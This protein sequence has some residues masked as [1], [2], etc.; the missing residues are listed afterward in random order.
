MRKALAQTLQ[1]G[2]R[3]RLALLTA[4]GALILGFA[5]NGGLQR[6]VSRFISGGRP[7]AVETTRCAGADDPSTSI[8]RSRKA[9]LCLHNVERHEQGVRKVH[10]NH[11]LSGV[12]RAQARD[13]VSRHYFDHVSPSHK[14]HMDR[15]AAS[16]Y[17]PDEGCWSAGE[18][19]LFAPAS[20]TPRQLLRT[21]MHSAAHRRNI[22]RRGWRD[23]GYGVVAKSPDGDPHGLT[24]VA[25]FGTRTCG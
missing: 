8:R 5:A 18:N 17:K 12:A 6:A 1:P 20:T 15:I 10:W 4:L 14:D 22:E 3:S 21:W 2:S 9:V 25:L 23:F 11:D 24:A 19:L 16:G 13:M 7:A